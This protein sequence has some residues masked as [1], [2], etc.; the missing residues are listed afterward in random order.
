MKL[1]TK[2]GDDGTTGLQGGRRVGKQDAIIAAI[3]S[4]DEV[5]AALG[6]TRSS[7][8]QEDLADLIQQIQSDLFAL[9]ADLSAPSGVGKYARH[10]KCDAINRV[11]RKI[12]EICDQLPPLTH[13]ILP[14]GSETASRLHLAR[15]ICRRAERQC[16]ALTEPHDINNTTVI[17][18][19]RLSDL[20][21]TL[22]RRANQLDRID[23]VPWIPKD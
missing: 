5:N 17:Y 9:G 15:T 20:L 8:Q 4:I 13:F 21:F 11:E 14:A 19:N 16:V 18:L 10:F 23:D 6:V 22:A 1:Y 12:D 3:G 2:T 7:C